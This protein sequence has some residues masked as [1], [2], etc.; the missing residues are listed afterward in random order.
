MMRKL[1]L[2]FCFFLTPLLM[3]AQDGNAP[4]DE[5]INVES[6]DTQMFNLSINLKINDGVTERFVSD[7]P[8]QHLAVSGKPVI[9]KITSG[10]N[11]KAAVRFTLY[12]QAEDTLL[13]LTQSTIMMIKEGKK[14]MFSAVKSMPI[15]TGEKVLF[16]PMG[17]M[18]KSEK[19]GYN[20]MLELD[21]TK[22]QQ[23]TVSQD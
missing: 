18:P 5:I 9:L 22:Y 20:C 6:S 11:L 3:F 4:S 19:S 16:F 13:L 15:K 1:F 23:K 21:V 12:E 8:V 7:K 17:F 14:Q 2:A 10:E